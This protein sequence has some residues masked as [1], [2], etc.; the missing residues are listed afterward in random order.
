[1]NEITL[2]KLNILFRFIIIKYLRLEDYEG[3][4]EEFGLA[5]DGVDGFLLLVRWIAVFGESAL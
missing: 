3:V 4:S 1:L 5:E 2:F